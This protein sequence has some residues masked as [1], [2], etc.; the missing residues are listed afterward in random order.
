[1]RQPAFGMAERR[2]QALVRA[3]AE[4]VERNGQV[5]NANE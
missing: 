2:F 3:G 4:A 5:V 1:L